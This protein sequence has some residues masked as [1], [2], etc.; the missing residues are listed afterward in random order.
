MDPLDQTTRMMLTNHC[1][2]PESSRTAQLEQLSRE[3]FL[4]FYMP[5]KCPYVAPSPLS[6]TPPPSCGGAACEEAWQF[7]NGFQLAV[8]THQ[9]REQIQSER[10]N[11]KGRK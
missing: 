5:W 7:Q 4:R 10:A 1:R 8:A 11:D 2:S 9:T 3:S 6:L